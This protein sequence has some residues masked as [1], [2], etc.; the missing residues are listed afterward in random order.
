MREK[1]RGKSP[2]GKGFVLFSLAGWREYSGSSVRSCQCAT[3][4][5]LKIRK[6]KTILKITKTTGMLKILFGLLKSW[7]K[8][9]NGQGFVL[10]FLGGST[11]YSASAV[12]S[13]Q[14][15]SGKPLNIMESITIVK[16]THATRIVK[17]LFGL[18]KS[19]AERPP[20]SLMRAV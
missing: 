8:R 7:G 18:L 13:F 6:R 12:R 4:N 5:P 15:R 9:P 3:A 11:V 1:G 19:L 2:I 17:L 16:M 20:P 10:F 14:M